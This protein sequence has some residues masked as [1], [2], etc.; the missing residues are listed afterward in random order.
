MGAQKR[1]LIAGNGPSLR[2][3]NFEDLRGI[4]WFGMN[5]AYRYWDKIGIYPTVYSCLDKVVV[6]SH[7]KEIL[8]LFLEKKIQKFFL[9][10]DILEELP[11]F[12]NDGRVF[13]LEDMIASDEPGSEVFKT[14]FSDKKTTG[15]WAVR[16]AVY[17]GYR[18]I[19]LSG[20][21]VNYVEIIEGAERTGTGLELKIGTEVKN[22][23]NYFFNDYQKPGDVYQ[24][25]NPER[26]FGNL[27]L[28]S[29]EALNVD[30]KRLG[31]GVSIMNTAKSSQ[32]HRFG[33]YEYVPLYEAL[34][35][36]ALQA[37]AVPLTIAEHRQL[38]HNISLWDLPAFHPLRLDSPLMGKISLHIFFDGARD[39]SVVG[40]I[41]CA[42]NATRR[43]KNMF[44]TLE[45]T[46]L[47]IPA[48][49]NHYIR[50][51]RETDE[52]R[53]M[54]P[55]LHFLAMMRCCKRY[56]YT[57]LME[58]DCVPAKSDWLTDLNAFCTR[59]EPF[60][61]AGAF[62]GSLEAVSPSF[63]LHI[64]GNAIYGTGD[65]GFIEFI[66]SVFIPA[67][68]YLIFEKSALSLAYDC[69]LSQ[70]LTYWISQSG[71]TVKD[72]RLD[73]FSAS[74]QANLEK[75]RYTRLIR[76]T[77]HVDTGNNEDTLCKL[78]D[79][80][81]VFVHSRS[82]TNLVT[83]KHRDAMN[84]DT[85][86]L[87]N[88]ALR[89]RLK[90]T[91]IKVSSD[92]LYAF[93]YYSNH[94]E[95]RFELFD[96]TNGF[97]VLGTSDAALA[98]EDQNVG[99]YLL[100][101]TDSP[102][103]GHTI[104]CHVSVQSENEQ[105]VSL[106]F[107]RNG[108]GK[109]VEDKAIVQSTK[110]VPSTA[111]L[112]IQCTEDYDALRLQLKPVGGSGGKL[113]VRFHVDLDSNPAN[114]L[115]AA[116]VHMP[117]KSVEEIYA[118]FGNRNAIR[119]SRVKENRRQAGA[120]ASSP[121]KR[122]LI[123]DSTPIGRHG[124]ATGQLKST[125]LAGWPDKELLQVWEAP[126]SGEQPLRL[127]TRDQ[128]MA[129]SRAK[130][131][132]VARLLQYC[133]D[134][135]PDVVYIRP[136][137]SLRLLRFAEQLLEKTGCPAV[138]HVMD[139]WPLRMKHED[140]EQYP[141]ADFLLRLILSRSNAQLS[142]CDDMSRE[143]EQR[144]GRSWSAVANG[145]DVSAYDLARKPRAPMS[146]ES[147][148]VIRYMGGV[149]QDMNYQSVLDFAA[150]ASSVSMRMP[151]RFEIYT[152]PWYREHISE[153][154]AGLPC[155]Q[156]MDLVPD[157]KYIQ[158]ICN[159]DALL[160]T[161]NFDPASIRY[162]GFSLANKMPE[163]LASGAPVIAYGPTS[164]ATIRY[165][166]HAACAELVTKRNQADL[167]Q[168]IELLVT[169]ET[170]RKQLVSAARQHALAK[171]DTVEIRSRFQR[172]LI[173]AAGSGAQGSVETPHDPGRLA[174]ANRLYREGR[175]RDA[176]N[177][178][179]ELYRAHPIALYKGNALRCSSRMCL[180]SQPSTI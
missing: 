149:A 86:S 121:R 67:L 50:D 32:L 9:V 177:M 114:T 147:P 178:Y 107:C 158:T 91:F 40:E 159:A 87:S 71:K 72:T 61:I 2:E 118:M 24:I 161:Y 160:L 80:D 105:T 58:T 157:D 29:F 150:A 55:N 151:L 172:I 126:N 136:N 79:G 128:S 165:L 33:V 7:A 68:T 137:E 123:I 37:I 25:P 163:C 10:K 16:F 6:K 168:A 44:S 13:F 38:V 146:P 54:G 14:A 110:D 36:P 102:T 4:D 77:S 133:I 124:S 131:M 99:A 167:I 95:M 106:R 42:W 39:A 56:R 11:D 148:F 145:V 83:E 144:Y 98:D 134:Y 41:E 169:N 94:P 76:N 127:I 51:P 125:L 82:L 23:P 1:I 180:A 49:L 35:S 122:L 174:Q 81:A 8:R 15:S 101:K 21:D 52:P 100:F 142:I 141:E 30:L 5:A 73:V 53:K 119:R 166:R 152:M 175:Y 92:E 26:H 84:W 138:V 34:R 135:Q 116:L 104:N 28:Q 31:L 66:D 63:A 59:S 93:H 12:P 109:F 176:M 139:D 17:L 96:R 103:T 90:D 171:L 179:M 140:P 120:A 20:I 97:V 64:N 78:L 22:N 155:T 117:D 3:V 115:R 156:V 47:S 75:F 60:W 74:I 57:Q 170:R 88:E 19:F 129:Q 111:T 162:I 154:L 164:I 70:L 48:D 173:N 85:E 132:D 27:H 143:Y 153:A 130:A 65:D 113:K 43:L 62:L 69:L 46:F 112:R 108:A 89:R 18:E 45:I